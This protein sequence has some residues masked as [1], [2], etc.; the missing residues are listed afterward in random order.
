MCDH[1]WIKFISSKYFMERSFYRLYNHT[2]PR[3]GMPWSWFV[4]K[5]CKTLGTSYPYEQRV[6]EKKGT[7]YPSVADLMYQIEMDK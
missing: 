7:E 6:S 2:Y 1:R 3:D 5:K 4:C